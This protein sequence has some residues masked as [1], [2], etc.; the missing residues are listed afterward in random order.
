MQTLAQEIIGS[1][2]QQYQFQAYQQA[3]HNVGK[4]Q[5]IIMLYDGV[6][7][8]VQ[9]AKSAHENVEIERRFN[10][11]QK[12]IN[13]VMGLQS[14]LDMQNY[15]D[16]SASLYDYYETIYIGLNGLIKGESSAYDAM[17]DDLKQMRNSWVS[18]DE[19]QFEAAPPVAFSGAFSGT[20]ATPQIN[21][22]EVGSFAIVA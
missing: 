5:Q 11:L 6:I 7:R 9:Q 12:A 14:S 3:S 17:I 20:F 8:F 21:A 18:A 15:P 4:G 19:S 22:N 13:V 16:I 1:I 10:M 2:M